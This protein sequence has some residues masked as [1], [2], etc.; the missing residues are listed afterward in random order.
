MIHSRGRKP[1]WF[2]AIKV[3]LLLVVLALYS[4]EL[5]DVN[6]IRKL[7]EVGEICVTYG[8]GFSFWRAPIIEHHKPHK[9]YYGNGESGVECPEYDFPDFPANSKMHGML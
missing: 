6:Q 1:G 9:L 3:F 2:V 7:R 5:R 8:T 4:V